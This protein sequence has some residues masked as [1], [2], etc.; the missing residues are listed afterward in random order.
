[1]KEKLNTIDLFLQFIFV[2]ISILG[3][4]FSLLSG[5]AVGLLLYFGLLFL[6]I[7]QMVSALICI[8]F[9]PE[10]KRIMHI[11]LS[12]IYILFLILGNLSNVFLQFLFQLYLLYCM[13]IAHMN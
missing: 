7:I 4:V 11:T 12:S 2:L 10:P 1:M 6:G 5:N 13:V 9:Y 3:S 8:S